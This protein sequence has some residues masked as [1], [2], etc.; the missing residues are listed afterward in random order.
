MASTIGDSKINLIDLSQNDL[1]AASVAL[2][3][4]CK[5]YNVAL[6]IPFD[7][8]QSLAKMLDNSS[9]AQ[10]AWGIFVKN[11]YSKMLI[12]VQNKEQ[13]KKM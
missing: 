6:Q 9:H 4:Y 2:S 7:C 3:Q 8:W 13:R 10:N 12:K 5:N 11:F 1:W